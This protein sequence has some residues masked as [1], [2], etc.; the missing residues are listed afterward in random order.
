MK[1]HLRNK[2]LLLL[3]MAILLVV[4]LPSCKGSSP[5]NPVMDNAGLL[6]DNDKKVISDKIVILDSL[7]LAQVAVVTITD[8]EGKKPL[9]YATDLANELGV[10]HEETN[11]GV[12]ILVKPK[13]SDSKGEIAISTGLG[14]EKILDNATVKSIVDDVMIPKFKENKYCEGITDAIDKIE[15]LLTESRF[16]NE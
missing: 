1:S 10:G 7:R 2:S 16:I 8:L 14:M 11:D 4:T 13:T 9:D 6:S 12:L 15:E 5:D 3:S